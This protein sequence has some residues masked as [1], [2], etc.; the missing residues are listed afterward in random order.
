M[1]VEP[2]KLAQLLIAYHEKF[3]RYVPGEAL[4]LLDVTELAPIIQDSLTTDV[5]LSET[6]C[7]WASPMEFSP[8]GC[9]IMDE[10]LDSALPT[11]YLAV[12]GDTNRA[13]SRPFTSSRR[14]EP[15]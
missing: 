10:T 4:R 8:R 1:R 13:S 3:Q 14:S 11:G 15:T 9:C 7:E 5:P 12:K 2:S 6:G